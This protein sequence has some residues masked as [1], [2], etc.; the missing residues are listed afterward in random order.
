ME[1]GGGED[2]SVTVVREDWGEE[3][4]RCGGE[5]EAMG[6]DK[7]GSGSREMGGG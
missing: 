4:G 6:A 5:E 1:R 3:K 7:G 2:G